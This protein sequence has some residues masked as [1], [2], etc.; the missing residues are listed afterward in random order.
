VQN[1]SKGITIEMSQNRLDKLG[2]YVAVLG[3][4]ATIANDYCGASTMVMS[5]LANKAHADVFSE[6]V[7]VGIAL[8]EGGNRQ[9]QKRMYRYMTKD[10]GKFFRRIHDRIAS[11]LATIHEYHENVFRIVGYGLSR[12]FFFQSQS[13]SKSLHC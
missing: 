3:H 13:F 12:G 2:E 10:D 9:V 8:L 5:M 1:E 7:E 11:E 4:A 6:V